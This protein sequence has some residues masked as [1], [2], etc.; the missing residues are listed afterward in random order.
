M[1]PAPLLLVNAATGFGNVDFMRGDFAE[2]LVD[3]HLA[4]GRARRDA[5]DLADAET[6]FRRAAEASRNRSDGQRELAVLH[7]SS[8][9]LAEARAA[10]L[11]A[12]RRNRE[13][14]EA[15][16][17]LY[18]AQVRS[19][20]YRNAEITLQ[21]IEE[22]APEDGG[23]HVA[24][25]WLYAA[26]PDP[27]RRNAAWAR[28]HAR[29]AEAAMGVDNPNAAMARALAEAASGNFA[30]AAD[31]AE[32]G[33]SLAGDRDDPSLREDFESLLGLIRQ[34]RPIAARPPLFARR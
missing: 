10:A 33:A 30:A 17:L 15:L 29:L 28:H 6:H 5:G 31:A 34:R 19:E 2:L 32:L 7:L 25:A 24:L 9:S 11:G 13:D 20:D 27:E 22:V 12:L 16:R 21:G 18:D 8:G 23:A 4:A 14:A 3:S 1:L 26:C